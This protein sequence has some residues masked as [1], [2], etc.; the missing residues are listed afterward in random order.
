M[1]ARPDTASPASGDEGEGLRSRVRI[2]AQRITRLADGDDDVELEDPAISHQ[3]AVSVK[4]FV[5]RL[6]ALQHLLNP[7]GRIIEKRERIQEL[8][9]GI[10]EDIACAQGVS[11]DATDA[12]DPDLLNELQSELAAARRDRRLF[13]EDAAAPR[14]DDDGERERPRGLSSLLDRP[15]EDRLRAVLGV[16]FIGLDRLAAVL[17]GPLSDAEAS[18][19]ARGLE[20]TWDGLMGIERFGAHARADELTPLRRALKEFVLVYRPRHLPTADGT[21]ELLA[22]D[23]LRERFPARF[24][25]AADSGQWYA[26]LPFSREPLGVGHWA[27]L[28]GQY[29][30]CTFRRPKIRLV[31]YAR[32][33]QVPAP[34]VRQK[35]ALEDVYDRLVVDAA[36]RTPFFHNCNSLTRTT[37]QQQG[38]PGKKQ[39]HVYYRDVQIRISGKRGVP[40]WRPGRPRWPGVLPA[41]VFP[42]APGA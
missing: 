18:Q 14:E 16:R 4:P 7:V 42:S 25:G 32:A 15:V 17:G 12:V 21:G 29:L 37:Y 3:L 5:D 23:R 30:N 27:L 1:N 34:A 38:E 36:L 24:L 39:V 11:Q 19:A 26:R 41:I 9:A 10:A 13:A 22:L 20:Q 28:D 33:N 40:H 6:T 31:M 8:R 2:L 35:S